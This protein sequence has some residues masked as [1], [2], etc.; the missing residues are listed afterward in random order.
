MRTLILRTLCLG[1]ALSASAAT[2]RTYT[3]REA[4]SDA[5]TRSDAVA[6][7]EAR[8]DGQKAMADQ[9]LAALFPAATLS[10]GWVHMDT[11]PYVEVE[12]DP[13]TLFPESVLDMLQGIPGVSMDDFQPNAMQLEMGRQDMFQFQLQGEQILFAGTGLHRQRAMAVA[14][15]RSAREE[16]RVTRH[17]V[18]YQTEELF[19]RLVLA[20][21]ALQVTTQAIETAE[22]HVGL[23]ENFVEVGLASRSDLMAAR[24]QLASL[25]LTQ[26]Q[27]RQGSELA[28]NAFRM[29]VHIPDTET[30]ELDTSSGGLPLTIPD[31]PAALNDMAAQS[32][33]EMRVL[34]QQVLST[35][36]AAGAAWASWLPAFALYGNVYLKNP[37]RA[38]EP[39]FYWSADFMIGMQWQLWDRGLALTNNRRARAGLNQINA[40][41]RQLVDGIELQI[42]Q[43]QA[44]SREADE[45]VLV[46]NEAVA[47]AEESLRLV[48]LNFGEGMARNVD[49]LEAQ[50]ALSKARLDALDAETQLRIAEAGLR[51]AV[52][53]DVQ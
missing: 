16:E 34:E 13:T 38:N 20:R 22:T 53:V 48:Q 5:V 28:E 29:I 1:L 14:Q 11:A 15:L 42:D 6:A 12:F 35:R 23:L 41:R 51:R 32:R 49:V 25:K 40:T 7:A 21:Q 24:V 19:W 30:V 36:H 33:P 52:G 27:I 43:A 3:L 39:E 17:E 18:S 37:D 2:A 31:D 46:A 10:G 47:L 4:V 8:T 45:M 50:T 9:A 44:A 26:L